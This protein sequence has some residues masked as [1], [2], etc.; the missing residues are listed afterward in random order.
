MIPTWSNLFP[1]LGENVLHMAIVNEDPAMVKFL[2]DNG[3]DYHQRAIG[4]FFTAD[5]QKSRRKDNFDHEWYDLPTETNYIG[6][7]L[8][9][10][11][12][13]LVSLKKCDLVLLQTEYPVALQISLE[14]FAAIG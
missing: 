4:N 5:D 10:S 13:G 8:P 14:S 12:E 1:S 6:Y 2:L 9:A 11:C 7:D 3:C